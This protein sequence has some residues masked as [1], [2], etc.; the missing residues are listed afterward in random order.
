M[1]R[2]AELVARGAAL[3]EVFDAVATEASRLLGG[4]V[5]DLFRFDDGLA[6]IVAARSPRRW[7]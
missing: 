6:T 1:R 4:G 7:E 3:A 2:V 5:T